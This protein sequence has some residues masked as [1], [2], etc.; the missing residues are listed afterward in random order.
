MTERFDRCDWKSVLFGTA[1]LAMSMAI[2]SPAVG[3]DEEKID[4]ARGASLYSDNCGRCHNPRGPSEFSDANWP[5]IVTHMRVIA[6]L[7]G[8]Q[9]RAIEA[10][11]RAS[12]NPPPRKVARM[13]VEAAARISGDELIK[14]YGCQGCHR[15]GDAGG[16]IGPDLNGVFSRQSEEWI[17]VQIQTPK[18]H[19]PKTVMP[20]FGLSDS[21]VAAIVDALRGAGRAD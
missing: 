13:K 8:E 2:V 11:L 14:T 20:Q 6:G 16:T 7:P 21:E 3:A 4:L 19:N 18:E 17:R 10:F 5:L 9:A 15:I 1:I 12:N